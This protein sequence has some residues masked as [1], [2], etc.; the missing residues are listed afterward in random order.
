MKIFFLGLLLLQSCGKDSFPRIYRS[1]VLD[2]RSHSR[3]SLGDGSGNRQADTSVFVSAVIV[4]ADYD[5]RRDSSYGAVACEIQLLRNGRPQFTAPAG[6]HTPISIS[7]DSHHLLGGHLYTESN[8]PDGTVICRDGE[9]C[10]SWPEPEILKGLFIKRGDIYTLGRRLDGS[11]FSFRQNGDLILSQE[12][13]VFGDFSNPAYGRTGA[14][15]ENDE[16]LCFC[17]RTSTGAYGVRDGVLETIRTSVRVGRIRDMR[18][19]GPSCYYTADYSSAMLIFSP[20]RTITLPTTDTWLSAGLFMHGDIPWF[21][22]DSRSKTICKPV[23][24]ADDS[25]AAVQ[26]PGYDNFIYRGSPDLYAL[27]SEGGTLRI[28]N[29]DG[30]LIYIRDSTFFFGPGSACCSGNEIYALIN[31]RERE[32]QPFIW[33]DGKETACGIN[34][35]LTG[36]EVEIS[37]PR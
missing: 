37:P 26:F 4:P 10:L 30:E 14:L 15:Y 27:N 31:P 23:D 5:W 21:M 25:A 32:E 22:A 18:L 11:G 24:Q 8:G 9:E 16:D 20:A 7:P 28:R 33:H 29:A 13:T 35:Y 19:I 34:G 36:I 17:F 3:D 2:G 12:G 6:I 1:D